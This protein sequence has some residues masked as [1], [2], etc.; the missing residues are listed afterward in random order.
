MRIY[1]RILLLPVAVAISLEG[2]CDLYAKGGTPCVAAHSMT[3]AL[4]GAYAGP[5][6]NVI[7]QPGN[8]TKDIFV[9]SAGGVADAASHDAFCGSSVCVVQRIYDQSPMQNHIGIEH[10]APNLGPPRNEQDLGVDFADSRSKTTLDGHPVYSA[11]FKG[12]PTQGAHFVGQGY[13]NRTAR[14]TAVDNE[15]QSM[16][17]VFSG[18]HFSGGCCFDYGNAENINVTSGQA[19]PM[20]DGSMEALPPCL[21]SVPIQSA[22]IPLSRIE[23]GR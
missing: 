4:Y 1:T 3:R 18:A 11:L 10:G 14:G 21:R 12:D 6:Y 23:A 13:S 9:L 15:P 22:P 7:K 5:L 20:F 17:A 19:G 2:P 8:A 16:Y